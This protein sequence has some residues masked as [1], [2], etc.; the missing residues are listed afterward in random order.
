MKNIDNDDKSDSKKFWNVTRKFHERKDSSKNEHTVWEDVFHVMFEAADF[1]EKESEAVNIM[2]TEQISSKIKK[3]KRFETRSNAES[4][5]H[6]KTFMK[7]SV[8]DTREHCLSE[9]WQIFEKLKS[10]KMKLSAY[11]IYKIKKIMKDDK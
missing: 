10:E 2:K 3:C 1:S 7:Y 11:H 6:K 5:N 8:C 4:K 9:C